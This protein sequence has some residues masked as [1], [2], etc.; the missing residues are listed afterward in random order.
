MTTAPPDGAGAVR[1]IVQLADPGPVTVP[2]EQ[3]KDEGKTA[4]LKPTVADCCWPLSEAVTL[5]LCV[6]LT[7]PV[8][9]EN[10]ALL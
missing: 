8:V 7:V 5:T 1:V 6:L 9:A 4:M 3:V 2:G 10:V